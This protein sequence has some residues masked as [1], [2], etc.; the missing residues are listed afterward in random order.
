VQCVSLRLCFV[1]KLFY[2]IAV[3]LTTFSTAEKNCIRVCL[4]GFILRAQGHICEEFN[5]PA[6][7]FLDTIN[8][9]S[10]SLKY[11]PTRGKYTQ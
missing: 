10:S 3:T 8:G 11:I 5:N 4:P 1:L 7:F 9:D 6:D 2:F